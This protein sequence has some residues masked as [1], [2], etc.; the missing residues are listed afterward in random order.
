MNQRMLPVKHFENALFHSLSP[1][2]FTLR[3]KRDVM[4]KMFTAFRENGEEIAL[5]KPIKNDQLFQ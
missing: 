2:D 1:Y 4:V 3:L 5:I